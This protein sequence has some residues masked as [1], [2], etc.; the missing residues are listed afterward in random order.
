MAIPELKIVN[1]VDAYMQWM[2]GLGKSLQFIRRGIRKIERQLLKTPRISGD[3]LASAYLN[4]FIYY[5]PVK[6]RQK[7]SS[8]LIHHWH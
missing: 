6:L 2:S 4:D 3:Y 1:Y 7:I 5:L 8:L